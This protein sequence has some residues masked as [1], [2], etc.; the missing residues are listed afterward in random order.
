MIERSVVLELVSCLGGA[1]ARRGPLGRSLHLPGSLLT[2]A[3]GWS[4]VP[5]VTA[6]GGAAPGWVGPASNTI[7]CL[8][9]TISLG[10]ALSQ[11]KDDDRTSV[12]R[13]R[14]RM[15]HQPLVGQRGL[16]CP[17]SWRLLS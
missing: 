10:L 15:S 1:G 4:C 6:T 17:W 7:R 11:D 13:V 14:A 8:R 9:C 3:T 5:A 16:T 2:P 12:A